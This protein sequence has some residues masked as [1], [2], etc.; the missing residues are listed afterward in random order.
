MG[1]GIRNP[2]DDVPKEWGDLVVS[3]QKSEGGPQDGVSE[4]DVVELAGRSRKG[5]QTGNDAKELVEH[6]TRTEPDNNK[7]RQAAVGEEAHTLEEGK[8]SMGYA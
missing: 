7:H 5:Y 3:H 4:G 1:V 2:R 6:N 8:G